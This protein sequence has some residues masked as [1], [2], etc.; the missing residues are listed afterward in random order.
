MARS[1]RPR[2]AASRW[3]KRRGAAPG[4]ARLSVVIPAYREVDH[5]GEAI[6]RVRSELAPVAEDGGLE[7][8]VVDD[9]S[10]DG[11]AEAARR[12]HADQ[13]IAFARNRGKGAAVRAGM[14]AANGRAVA[15][16]DADL[17]YA[18]A[19]I[20][21]LLARVEQGWDVVVGSRRHGDTT[22]VAEARRLRDLGG[23]AVNLA[24]RVVVRGCY[25]DTQ[26]GL[27]A[28]R[29][30]AARLLFSHGR[31]DGFAF[32]VEVFHLAERYDLSLVEV[33]VR[34]ENFDQSTVRVAHDAAWLLVD[35][36]RIASHG[37]C[38]HYDL[39]AGEALSPAAAGAGAPGGS[40]DLADLSR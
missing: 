29:S 22:T 13:V 1:L 25:G 37:A 28:F 30:D 33:P 36:A 26:C 23:R 11:T 4:T 7:V 18:P 39:V 32:D 6:R 10:G 24:S 2:R 15:F 19:Q 20:A 14:L 40:P 12:Y 9:G 17:S 35:L 5:I 8:L 31:V 21:D 16:T 34:V 3:A 27:K 38:G